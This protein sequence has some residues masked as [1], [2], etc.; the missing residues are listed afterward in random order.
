VPEFEPG[1]KL[2]LLPAP[3]SSPLELEE[4][5]IGGGV[6]DIGVLVIL[7]W[8]FELNVVESVKLFLRFFKSNG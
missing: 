3:C 8:P 2:C 7:T 6:F 4:D 5:E 1:L